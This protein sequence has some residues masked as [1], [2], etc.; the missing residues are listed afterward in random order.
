MVTTVASPSPA[1]QSPE[2][3]TE[4]QANYGASCCK[5]EQLSEK[6]LA[7]SKT[8]VISGIGCTLR[9]KNDAL[10]VFP[11]KTHAAQEQSTKILHRAVHGVMSIILITDK[12]L[13]TLDAIKWCQEQNIALVMLGSRGNVV[14]SLSDSISDAKLRR[15]QYA[16]M[17]N[18]K[19]GKICYELVKRKVT[20]QLETLSQHDELP[21]KE[22]AIDTLE[23]AVKWFHL[24][25]TPEKF[26]EINWLRTFEGRC[27]D[28]Y[29]SAW[30]SLPIK[31]D[32]EA[33]RTIPPHW[34]TVGKR[35]SP[36]SHKAYGRRG[37]NTSNTSQI[38]FSWYSVRIAFHGWIST[39]W[40]SGRFFLSGW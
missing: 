19:A 26:L 36:L 31:W 24:P 2:Q 4:T 14:Q 25:H 3:L 34:L 32:R 7:K 22:H 10:V 9:V 15:V 23:Q 28:S 38:I 8:I 1:R 16:A 29:F 37:A 6:K 21:G 40:F 17:D 5:Y 20:S 35:S 18:G 11:G 27:A 13:I 30:C 33:K 39:M 12:G